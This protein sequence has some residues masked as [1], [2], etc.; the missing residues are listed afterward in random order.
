MKEKNYGVVVYSHPYNGS[1]SHALKE[2][3]V[4][5]F[6]AKGK[7][8]KVIDLISDEFN[9]IGKELNDKKTLK[10]IKEY[11]DIILGADEL[12]ITYPIWWSGK[13]ALIKG[14]LDSV[15]WDD[16]F[17]KVINGKMVPQQTHFK[18]A[19]VFTTTFTPNIVTALLLRSP[20]RRRAKGVF[21]SLGFK[22][23]EFKNLDKV[24]D[25]LERR[26]RYIS[27]ITK[28]IGGGND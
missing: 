18:N 8:V 9:S 20:N 16:K 28:T 5:G 19:Y 15:L 21:G 23:I 7:E 27:Y 3:A 24:K 13:P 25:S 14:F 6:K 2:A 1:F 26:E 4:A 22:N 10:Q 17:I 12:V 11:Q